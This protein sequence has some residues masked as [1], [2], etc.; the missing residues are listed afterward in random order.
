MCHARVAYATSPLYALILLR[1]VCWKVGYTVTVCGW[2]DAAVL[3]SSISGLYQHDV[4]PML[5]M[6]RF[7]LRDNDSVGCRSRH[8]HSHSAP[9][10]YSH[11]SRD[12]EMDERNNTRT[13]D[14]ESA[15]PSTSSCPTGHR[16]CGR[17]STAATERHRLRRPAKRRGGAA[18]V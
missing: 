17:P 11:T 6:S 2:E 13:V 1:F 14:D 3:P 9:V 10:L 18:S 7:W 4:A 15:N 12:S 5:Q 16:R 8:Y